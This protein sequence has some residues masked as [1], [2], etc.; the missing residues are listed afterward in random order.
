V[1]IF[2]VGKS[3]NSREPAAFENYEHFIPLG[4]LIVARHFGR[5]GEA[6]ELLAGR[7]TVLFC[8]CELQDS[9]G[10]FHSAASGR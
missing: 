6:S 8:E 5:A 10:M 4:A 1:K 7:D 2:R 9:G 3:R